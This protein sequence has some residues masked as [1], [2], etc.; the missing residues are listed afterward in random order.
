MP[1]RRITCGNGNGNGRNGNHNTDYTDEKYHRCGRNE[2]EN[3]RT[4]NDSLP[5][6]VLIVVKIFWKKL[7]VA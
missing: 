6:T 3:D 5:L 2:N 4:R 1:Q 7:N